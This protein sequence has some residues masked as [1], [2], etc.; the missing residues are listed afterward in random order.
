VHILVAED[1]EVLRDE[2]KGLLQ[3]R[4]HTVTAVPDGR[5]ARILLETE[6]FD[7]VILD[8]ELPHI[9]GFQVM[10]QVR[11]ARAKTAFVVITGHANPETRK[12]A[13]TLGAD[14]F[15][16]K[17]FEAS[18]LERIVASIEKGTKGLS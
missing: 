15:L 13:M 16:A 2:L 3:S 1:D 18:E 5:M 12:A 8:Y 9:D 10:E 17:P 6:P 11:Q 7:M 14:F 4:R